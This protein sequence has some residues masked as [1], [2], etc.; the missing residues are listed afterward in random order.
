MRSDVDTIAVSTSALS[1]N[2]S[3]ISIVDEFLEPNQHHTFLIF[4][5]NIIMLY[6]VYRSK[7]MDAL[8]NMDSSLF[9]DVRDQTLKFSQLLLLGTMVSDLTP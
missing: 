4:V 3:S 8:V 9:Q 2:Y 1:T 6:D 5:M 7:T